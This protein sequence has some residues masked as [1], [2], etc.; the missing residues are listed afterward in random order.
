MLRPGFTRRV[1]RN[2]VTR[3]TA[4]PIYTQQNAIHTVALYVLKINLNIIPHLYLDPP[5]GLFPLRFPAKFCIFIC[6]MLPI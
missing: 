2:V 1:T 4:D 5:N 6:H 3:F